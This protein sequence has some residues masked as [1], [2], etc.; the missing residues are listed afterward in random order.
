[1]QLEQNDIWIAFVTTA[2]G[3]HHVFG[4]WF[5]PPTREAVKPYAD[6]VAGNDDWVCE[7]IKMSPAK[8]QIEIMYDPEYGSEKLCQCGHPYYRHFDPYEGMQP[9]GCKYCSCDR[10]K[11]R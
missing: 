3:T 11:E 5:S 10:F 1:M 2:I 9:V 7:I 4:Y 8:T 6:E